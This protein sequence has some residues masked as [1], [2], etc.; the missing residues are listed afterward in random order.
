[1][2]TLLR[3]DLRRKAHW[4]YGSDRW[5]AILKVLLASGTMAM[6]LYRLMQ[7]SRRYRLTPLELIF[8]KLNAVCCQCIIGRGAEFGPGFVV[9]YGNGIVINGRVRGG[10]N[11]T[12]YHQVTLGG[13]QDRVPILGDDVMVGAGAKVIGPVRIGDGSRIAVNSI[14]FR[15]D[16]PPYTTVMG[17]PAQP[18]QFSK[19]REP[20]PNDAGPC[21]EPIAPS[22]PEFPDPDGPSP[23]ASAGEGDQADLESRL[24]ACFAAVFG[25]V[26]PEDI[27]RVSVSTMEGWDSLASATLAAHIEEEFRLRIAASEIARLGSFSR[28]LTS[29]RERGGR[30]GGGCSLAEDLIRDCAE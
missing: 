20:A 8:N 26:R 18:V 5:P 27:P 7:W 13:Q 9:L 19:S 16:V 17:I 14:V 24:V 23:L 1:M 12:L 4:M 2:L 10:S 22:S 28:I 15:D 25:D 6:V 3:A 30:L 11:V 29:V 21:R